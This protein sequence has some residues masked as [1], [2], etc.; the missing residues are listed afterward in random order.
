MTRPNQTRIDRTESIGSALNN[1]LRR[2]SRIRPTKTAGTKAQKRT[3][4]AKNDSATSSPTTES[5]GNS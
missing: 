1:G 2:L 5:G 4:S 3:T